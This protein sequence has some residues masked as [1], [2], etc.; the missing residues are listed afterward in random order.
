MSMAPNNFVMFGSYGS[1]FE[2]LKLSRHS[3]SWSHLQ[4]VGFAGS[5]GGFL[6]SFV[7]SPFELVKVQQQTAVPGLDGRP[8]SALAS[9]R[10]I[11]Q[12][13]GAAGLWRGATAHNSCFDLHYTTHASIC[14]TP[15]IFRSELHR[16]LCDCH[17][18]V[19]RPFSC[20]TLRRS[21]RNY[22]APNFIL[23]FLYQSLRA[24]TSWST[25]PPSRPLPLQCLAMLLP[26]SL[27]LPTVYYGPH[28]S[29]AVL[30]QALP[31]GRWL[32]QWTWSRVSC[33]LHPLT[34]RNPPSHPQYHPSIGAPAC[35]DSGLVP[36]RA[37]S[38]PCP[39]TPLR[40]SCS[41]SS[42]SARRVVEPCVLL[43]PNPLLA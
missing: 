8:P 42:K 27:P 41:S 39:P 6:Q 7:V 28:S 20:A 18:Q 9:V 16:P 17:L 38:A 10:L 22:L 4:R 21:A 25:K 23:D 14:I 24:G 37:S 32:C 43:R 15:L 30:R 3:E 2:A 26:A 1:A 36:P 33:R 29:L 35:R 40:F 34:N 31:A 5:V 12:Q 11:V 13:H 19:S